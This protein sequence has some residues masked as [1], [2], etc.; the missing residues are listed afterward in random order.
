MPRMAALYRMPLLQARAELEGFMHAQEL[1][2][3]WRTSVE[4]DNVS[5]RRGERDRERQTTQKG[6]REVS[7]EEGGGGA[8]VSA[9]EQALLKTC[10]CVLS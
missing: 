4:R 5:G 6:D 2:E 7:E 10:L 9:C 8:G 3:R 1:L